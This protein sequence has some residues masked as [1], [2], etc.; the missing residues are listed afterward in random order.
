M[1][2]KSGNAVILRGG[3][4]ANNSCSFIVEVLRQT[5][6][7]E[8]LSP[9]IL[10]IVENPDRDQVL[11]MIK[12]NQYIDVIIPRGGAG[13]IETVVKNATI[14]VIETGV[15]NCHIYIDKTADLQSALNLVENAKVQRP[16]VCNAV[17][18]LLVNEGIAK[19][20]LPMLFQILTDKGVAFKGCKLT[21]EILPEVELASENDWRRNIWI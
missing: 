7:E 5:L 1:C 8:G 19:Q 2:L 12:L 6:V 11:Q 3:S 13:L 21:K 16:G 10:Q 18:T 20:F 15:G 17:E 9:E 4:E 14:P